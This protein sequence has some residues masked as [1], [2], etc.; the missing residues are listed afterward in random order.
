MRLLLEPITRPSAEPA[1]RPQAEPLAKQ[2]EP[3]AE[4]LAEPSIRPSIEAPAQPLRELSARPSIIPCSEPSVEPFTDSSIEP[5]TEPAIEPATE[6][7]IEPAEEPSTTLSIEEQHSLAASPI[8]ARGPVQKL[9]AFAKIPIVEK[10][11]HARQAD[12]F[13]AAAGR[14]ADSFLKKPSEKALLHFLLL[15]RVLGLGFQKGALAATLNAFPNVI[16]TLDQEEDPGA[17]Q[18]RPLQPRALQPSLGQSPAEQARKLLERGFVGRASKALIN[19]IPLALDSDE[20]RAILREKHPIGAKDPFQGKTRPRPGQ[21]IQR[22]AILEAIAS[23]NKEKAPGLSGWTRPLLD[24]AIARNSSITSFLRLLADMIRQGTAPGADLLC[25]SRLIGLEKPDKGIRPIAIGDMIY[26]VATKAILIT[27]FQ[28]DMLLPNQLGVS[29][30]GGVE[31]AIFLLEDAIQGPNSHS[32]QRLASLDLANAFNSI[33]RSSIAA[34]VAKYAPTFYKAAAWA[35]NSPSLLVTDQGAILASTQGV[36]QGDPLGP[37]LFSLAFRPTLERLIQQLPNAILVA[38]LDDLYIL[39]KDSTSALEIAIEVFQG[40]PLTLNLAKSQE[41]DLKDLRKEGLKAL[42]SYIGPLGLRKA[43]LQRKINSLAKA[44]KALK[45]LPKQHALLLLR[46]SIHLLLRHLLRQLDP[47]GLE[48]LWGIADSLIK[49]AIETLAT[50]SL[51]DKPPS[52]LNQ[53]LIA[54]PARDGGLGIPLH[55][56]LAYGL[57]QAAREASKGTLDKIQ[58]NLLSNLSLSPGLSP[59]SSPGPSLRPAR[60][61]SPDKPYKLSAQEVLIKANKER[62]QRLEETLPNNQLRARLENASYLGRKWL[63]VLPTQKQLSFADLEATEAIRSRLFLPI[64]PL[65]S[66]CS[67]CGS[68]VSLSHEDTCKGASRRWIS[69]HNQITRAF[70]KTLASRANLEVEEEPKISQGD[71]LRADFAVTLGNSR[72]FYDVQIVAINKESAKEDAYS[73]LAEAAEEKRRKYSSLGAF[74][75]PLIFSAGGLMEKETAK[76]YKGLQELVGPTAA[77]WL[78]SSIGLTLTKTRAFSAASIAKE[79]PNNPEASW[80]AIREQLRREKQ[81]Y[82]V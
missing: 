79:N 47:R 49:E 2:P 31:P 60:P 34:A 56:E 19:P 63:R 5:A 68:R 42:G 57:Y 51:G 52:N 7:A 72:Y 70:I 3:L 23:I 6:P 46:G 20:N 22:K 59:D 11:L 66:P 35:Y 12:L 28:P 36:R 1:I 15:P 38:Y 62:L 9:L 65:D 13:A 37:F 64:R 4:P 29:S 26:R 55:K 21:P 61:N 76:T 73:T 58:R 82:K 75:R 32:F 30:P 24:L 78:D 44:L 10:R 77:S 81:A 39:N 27:S 53:D 8:L 45:D 41:K 48:D 33:D 69:R 14:A 50:R 17:L 67:Y 71:S 18:P 40:S 80:E 74:F 43:F 16:P 54:L 25:A